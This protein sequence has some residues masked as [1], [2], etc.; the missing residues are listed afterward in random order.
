MTP[1]DLPDASALFQTMLGVWP[2]RALVAAIR[3]DVFAPLAAG[4]LS[5]GELATRLGCDVR[6]LSVLADALAALGLL[7]RERGRLMLSPSAARYLVPGQSTYLGDLALLFAQGMATWARLEDAV[8]AGRPTAFGEQADL[9]ANP[10]V[11]AG[12][13]AYSRAWAGAGAAVG[14]ALAG[15]ID[16]SGRRLLVDLGGGAGALVAAAVAATPGLRAVVFDSAAV[17][18]AAREYLARS[19]LGE[20]VAFQVGDFFRDPLPAGMDVAMLSHVAHDWAPD[21]VTALF[22]RIQAALAPAGVIVLHEWLCADPAVGKPAT[23]TDG[24]L[25]ELMSLNLLG[26]TRGGANRSGSEWMAR[27]K[28]VGFVEPAVRPGWPPGSFVVARKPSP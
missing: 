21:E 3:L 14:R 9:F 22:G 11:S 26:L 5:L 6:G 8:R 2:Q 28:A 13:A 16:L 12:M 4:P 19:G 10:Y 17:E 7:A 20:R 15:A 1:D 27:L 24:A 23:S 25:A 18:P